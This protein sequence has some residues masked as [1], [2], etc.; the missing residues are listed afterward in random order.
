[1]ILGRGSIASVI[2]DREG[3]IFFANGESNRRPLTEEL[4][5][6]EFNRICSYVRESQNSMFV[7]ISGLNIY[8]KEGDG[9]SEYTEHKLEMEQHVK[10]LFPSYCIIRLGSI[11]WGDNPNTLVNALKTKVANEPNYIGSP[12]YR[13]LHTKEELTHWFGMI[14]RYGKHEMNITGKLTWVPDLV[15][16]IKRGEL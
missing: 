16:Q 6:E 5:R 10:N 2:P 14:P 13:Y 15:E 1:M 4:K 8:Y 3:F 11:I 7:Y 12:V 9:R